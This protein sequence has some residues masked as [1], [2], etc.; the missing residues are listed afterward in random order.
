MGDDARRIVGVD[1]VEV[2]GEH[3]LELVPEAE[4]WAERLERFADE[5]PWPAERKRL[6]LGFHWRT[7][8]DEGEAL[9]VLRALAETAEHE[10]LRPRWG[11]KV[12]EIRPPVDADK[13]T[14]VRAL[15][16]RHDLK[17]ALYAGD[18][19]TDVDAFRALEG[20]DLA[21]RVAVASPEG[22]REL[23]EAADLVVDGPEELL[24]LLRRL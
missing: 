23:R 11:R 19:T 18:D 4:E 17:R 5:A 1:G 3:G 14:A 15:L 20:L 13:G 7:A 12:L 6:T 10:G 24:S 8:P 22:P 2:V 21:V 9:A 16:E